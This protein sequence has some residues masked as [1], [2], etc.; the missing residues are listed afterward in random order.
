MRR[1]WG[2]VSEHHATSDR[3]ARRDQR[4]DYFV[5]SLPS[6]KR[7]RR[8]PGAERVSSGR[9]VAS[10]VD[11]VRR[12]GQRRGL[13]SCPAC[14]RPDSASSQGSVRHFGSASHGDSSPEGGVMPR[15]AGSVP[16]D[17]VVDAAT[18]PCP[19]VVAGAE[20]SGARAS[21]AGGTPPDFMGAWAATG[22]S[23]GTSPGPGL[24]GKRSGRS[25]ISGVSG[26]PS[27]SGSDSPA[28]RRSG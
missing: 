25:M 21:P 22:R 23:A 4:P 2:A 10:P 14:R 7:D 19:P 12:N 13:L 28:L 26:V 16:A 27:C 8:A 5:E 20:R 1:Q 17:C 15:D 3:I 6:S 24:C 18:V 9:S 11:R